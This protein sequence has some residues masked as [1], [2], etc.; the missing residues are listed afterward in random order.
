[1]TVFDNTLYHFNLFGNMAC[2]S[3]FNTWWQGIEKTQHVVKSQR[4]FLHDFHRLKLFQFGLFCKL[5][6]PLIVVAFQMPS[7]SDITHI[8]NLVSKMKQVAKYQVERH[9]R[10]AVAQVHVAINRGTTH[11]HTHKGGV[12]WLKSL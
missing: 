2:S 3:G 10:T 7:I 6:V 5:V 4:V 12:Q 9:K 11:V 8:A 1:I